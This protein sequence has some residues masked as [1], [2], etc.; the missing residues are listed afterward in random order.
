MSPIGKADPKV[1]PPVELIVSFQQLESGPTD[2][3]AC[4]V[5]W[6]HGLAICKSASSTAYAHTPSR[7]Q[8]ALSVCCKLR[9]P[10]CKEHMDAAVGSESSPRIHSA[11]QQAKGTRTQPSFTSCLCS[12]VPCAG[13]GHPPHLMPCHL[14]SSRKPHHRPPGPNACKLAFGS[15]ACCFTSVK[16]T[17]M[18]RF[19]ESNCIGQRERTAARR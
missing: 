6:T 12:R 2:W 9:S 1:Q 14:R 7:K 3:E 19:I 17:C 5:A 4:L 15:L 18:W 10:A 8:E 16:S 11:M 13:D